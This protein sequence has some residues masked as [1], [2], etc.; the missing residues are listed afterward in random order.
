APLR[1]LQALS[2]SVSEEL[3]LA[4][5]MDRCQSYF[6]GE[7]RIIDQAF[8]PRLPEGMIRCYLSLNEVVGFGHQLITA[9]IAPPASGDPPKPGPRIMHPA[10]AP[11]FADLRRN[12]ET[13]S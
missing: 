5:F 9:L 7:G 3:S 1:V 11:S 10:D 13:P 8:Q 6:A 4:A 2:G 12:M